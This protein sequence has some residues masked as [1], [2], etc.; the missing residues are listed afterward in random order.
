MNWILGSNELAV[1]IPDSHHS[2]LVD[3]F[4]TGGC[5]ARLD[6]YRDLAVQEEEKQ[7]VLAALTAARAH[8]EQEVRAQIGLRPGE[9]EG[10][11]ESWLKPRLKADDWYMILNSLVELMEFA[12]DLGRDVRMLSD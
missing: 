9:L 2:A 12:I 7:P 8:Q 3:V 5:L 6:P 4:R 11:E 10:W 1:V